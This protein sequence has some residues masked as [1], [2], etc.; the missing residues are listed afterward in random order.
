MHMKS[1][2]I[3]NETSRV[4]YEKSVRRVS[5]KIAK[6]IAFRTSAGFWLGFYKVLEI[7]RGLYNL[8]KQMF[9]IQLKMGLQGSKNEVMVQ[10]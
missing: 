1:W 8:P 4:V 7:W 5:K 3:D 6:K 9:Y 2:G 10:S